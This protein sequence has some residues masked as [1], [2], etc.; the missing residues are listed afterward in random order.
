MDRP[1]TG[2][3]AVR[4][5]R[6]FLDGG[7]A[8]GAGADGLD[9]PLPRSAR[10]EIDYRKQ[11][12]VHDVAVVKVGVELGTV[13]VDAVAE[14]PVVERTQR[15]VDVELVPGSIKPAQKAS[16]RADGRR[17]WRRARAR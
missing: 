2:K 5:D 10:E 13:A 7:V 6:T 8:G 1:S 11:I 14:I 17:L 16:E 3:C 12:R 9:E 4:A 15:V